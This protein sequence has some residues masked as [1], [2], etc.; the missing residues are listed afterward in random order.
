MLHYKCKNYQS[1]IRKKKR[2]CVVDTLMY[3]SHIILQNKYTKYFFAYKFKIIST[4]T[5]TSLIRVSQ[6]I[7]DPYIVL[8]S[9]LPLAQLVK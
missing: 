2:G 3:L 5:Y 6:C 4:Y 1:L 7:F 9:K 8:A